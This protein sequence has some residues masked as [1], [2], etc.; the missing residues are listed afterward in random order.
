MFAEPYRHCRSK[1]LRALDGTGGLVE[2]EC[3]GKKRVQPARAVG[4][5]DQ[6]FRSTC[7]EEYLPTPS[8]RHEVISLRIGDADGQEPASPRVV[9]VR[10]QPS[11]RA[12]REAVRC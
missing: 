10:D 9:K 1:H 3:I 5:V 2:D 7:L 6:E 11:L 8:A 4:R 12:Q